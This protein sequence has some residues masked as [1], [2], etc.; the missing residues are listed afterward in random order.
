MLMLAW[1][2]NPLNPEPGIL[3]LSL[4]HR[5]L[6]QLRCVQFSKDDHGSRLHAQQLL[7]APR[8]WIHGVYRRVMAGARSGASKLTPATGTTRIQPL[9]CLAQT[10]L[11]APTPSCSSCSD[12]LGS[13]PFLDEEVSVVRK[14]G[15][16]V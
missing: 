12:A 11:T 10:F 5:H 9:R 3:A 14:V 15:F 6:Q 16:R 2:L 4:N 13:G 8:L 1:S 7:N